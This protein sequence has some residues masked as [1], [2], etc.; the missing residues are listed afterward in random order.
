[1]A[2]NVHSSLVAKA[3]GKPQKLPKRVKMKPLPGLQMPPAT[4]TFDPRS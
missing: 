1:M 2:S 3:Y 4:L